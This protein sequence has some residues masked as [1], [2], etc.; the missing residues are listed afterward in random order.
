MGAVADVVQE[1]AVRHGI[2]IHRPRLISDDPGQYVLLA[3]HAEDL[4]FD[5]IWMGDHIALPA[6]MPGTYPY[7][8]SKTKGNVVAES[9]WFDAMTTFAFMAGATSRIRF[10]TDVWILPLRPPLITAKVLSTLDFLSK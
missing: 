3:R 2:S 7:V 5:S 6:V 4:G 1:E 10:A 9:E 8:T